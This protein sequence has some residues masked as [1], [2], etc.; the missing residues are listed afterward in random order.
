MRGHFFRDDSPSG[1]HCTVSDAHAVR[2]D[3]TRSD[4]DIVLYCDTLGCDS[5]SHKR[6]ARVREYV[7]DGR[8]LHERRGVYAITDFD[9]TLSSQY[10]ELSNKAIL[11]NPDA[12]M[13]KIAKVIDV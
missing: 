3:R 2:D 8:E 11:P 9:T 7:I 4:P 13:G 12:S 5:L 1:N 10:V 6:P